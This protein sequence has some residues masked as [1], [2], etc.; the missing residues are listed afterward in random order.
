MSISEMIKIEWGLLPLLEHEEE[1]S[2]KA[3]ELDLATN[4]D[5]FC[6]VIRIMYKSKKKKQDEPTEDQKQ[7]ADYGWRLLNGWRIPPGTKQDG[8]FD[9]EAFD[10]WLK[11]VKESC[12]ESG[13][14]EVALI[15]IGHVLIHAPSDPS[16]L[17]IHGSI[18]NALNA[19]DAKVMRDDYS[20]ALYNLRGTHLVDPEGKPEMELAENYKTKADAVEAAGYHRLATT[21]RKLGNS[22]EREAERLRERDPF[23]D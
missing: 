4:P 12:D 20:T 16:G 9:G 14:L 2:P 10:E 8:T 13:H 7:L 11:K 3:L 15:N 1:V 22:Y 6:E 17:W 19:K 18:A 23:D 21:L 5:S